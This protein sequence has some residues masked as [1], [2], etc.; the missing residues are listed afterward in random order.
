MHYNGANSIRVGRSNPLFN[1]T[2]LYN[3]FLY[4]GVDFM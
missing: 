4:N 3:T 1:Y 2:N